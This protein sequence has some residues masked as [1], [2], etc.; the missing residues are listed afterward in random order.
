M[1]K[2]NDLTYLSFCFFVCVQ[3]F[4]YFLSLIQCVYLHTLQTCNGNSKAT[5]HEHTRAYTGASTIILSAFITFTEQAFQEGRRFAVLPNL[6]S[7]FLVHDNIYSRLSLLL[8]LPQI[9]HSHVIKVTVW[10]RMAMSPA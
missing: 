10:F 1:P 5:S 4:V 3:F 8:L 9:P 6:V 7:Y 2:N